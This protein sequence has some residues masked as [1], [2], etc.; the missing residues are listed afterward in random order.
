MRHSIFISYCSIRYIACLI[1]SL[2]NPAF[3]KTITYTLFLLCSFSIATAQS[4][5]R[6]DQS[7]IP[8]SQVIIENYSKINLGSE[9]ISDANANRFDPNN[10]TTYLQVLS[11]SGGRKYHILLQANLVG[12]ISF[13]AISN[14]LSAVFNKKEKPMFAFT[15]C[16][17]E[18]N[19]FMSA[20]QNIDAAVNCIMER[21]EYCSN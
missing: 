3:M 10:A 6:S 16:M 11:G 21:L 20:R 14:N 1:R 12:K 5:N 2:S 17:N 9:L 4:F 15:H 7:I 13:L 19:S 8:A 18:L